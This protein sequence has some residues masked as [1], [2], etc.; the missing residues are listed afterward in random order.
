MENKPKILIVDDIITNIQLLT[1]VLSVQG[2]QI[3][4]AIT[5]HEAIIKAQELIPDLIL[6][7]I[8]MPDMDGY[9]VAKGILQEPKTKGIPI[10][11]ITGLQTQEFI[12][13][14]LK[15]GAVDYI[16]KPFNT[17]EL[18]SRVKTHVELKQS[19]DRILDQ[20]NQLLAYQEQLRLQM[21]NK[22]KF[23]SIIASD[24]NVGFSSFMGL[25]QVL[26]QEHSHMN[27]NERSLILKNVCNSGFSLLN[28]LNKLTTWSQIQTNSLNLQIIQI[29][30]KSI[31][32]GSIF[33]YAEKSFNKGIKIESVIDP[34]IEIFVDYQYMD[35]IL[36]NII[37]NAIKFSN[38]DNTIN[39]TANVEDNTIELIIKDSGIGINA[40]DMEK[41][42]RIDL[43]FS[44]L[45]TKSEHGV[46]LGLILI[47]SLLDI[48]DNTINIT[49]KEG[50]GT[51]V[52]LKF[53]K[54][55]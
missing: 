30:L 55:R 26:T 23:F 31:V 36:D 35:I 5:G 22:N 9:E 12:N 24:L 50:E 43:K 19:R 1:T 17:I 42:F 8:M 34:S 47:K 14:G 38:K 3:Y 11:F 37:E 44:N 32:E 54:M 10:I 40:D 7:D 49:S 33:R 25:V 46:G 13:K 51:T 29:K 53:N 20:N 45:G 28:V 41:L 4:E 15:L 39:I 52:T 27:E 16:T 6:L 48:M 21:D 2:Y 18:L